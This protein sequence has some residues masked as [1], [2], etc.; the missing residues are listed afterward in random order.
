MHVHTHIIRTCMVCIH[1]HL[2]TTHTHMY[3]L[4]HSPACIHPYMHTGPAGATC[5]DHAVS[6]WE[7]DWRDI[8]GRQALKITQAQVFNTARQ[9]DW[10]HP[11]VSVLCP[12]S[13][14][15]SADIWLWGDHQ[16]WQGHY[17]DMENDDC[18]QTKNKEAQVW[19]RVKAVPRPSPHIPFITPSC[20]EG[21][22]TV[23]VCLYSLVPR[24]DI[25]F[26]PG[27]KT[28]AWFLSLY[29]SYTRVRLFKLHSENMSSSSQLKLIKTSIN[30]QRIKPIM[31]H[32][33]TRPVFLWE[34]TCHTCE[35]CPFAALGFPVRRGRNN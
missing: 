4:C 21:L 12:F 22:G 5:S 16:G 11:R 7:P 31:L 17:R 30:L 8:R 2:Y 14:D 13:G 23:V 35:L 18:T 29:L 20:G 1:L 15:P 24:S 25:S 28:F 26:M 19:G 33:Q 3:T 32:K 34:K 9:P 6:T 27:N 10:N